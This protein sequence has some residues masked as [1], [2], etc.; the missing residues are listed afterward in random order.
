MQ[1][2]PLLGAIYLLPTKPSL[3][4]LSS[5]VTNPYG[6]LTHVL[7]A[8]SSFGLPCSNVAQRQMGLKSAVAEPHTLPSL[9]AAAR[10]GRAPVHAN[11]FW[12]HQLRLMILPW[13]EQPH[14]NKLIHDSGGFDRCTSRLICRNV[15]I[16]LMFWSVWQKRNS[17]VIF[18]DVQQGIWLNDNG[19]CRSY[20]FGSLNHHERQA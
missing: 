12:T 19:K 8:G 3:G 7:G 5:C 18:G 14:S 4:E 15:S 10:N 1:Q 16:I 2:L 20:V 9:L 11:V 13:A 6:K 17:R